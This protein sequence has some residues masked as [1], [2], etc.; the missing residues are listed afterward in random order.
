MTERRRSRVHP[1]HHRPRLEDFSGTA[2]E[3]P[4]YPCADGACHASSTPPQCAALGPHT[5][6]GTIPAMPAHGGISRPRPRRT[7]S[8][9]VFLIVACGAPALLTLP[10]C[11]KALY[12]PNDDRTQYDRYRR[13]RSELAPAYIEDEFGRRTPNL[14]ER[15]GPGR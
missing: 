11:Q 14:R 4:A 5:R 10:G 6:G 8:G 1:D 9:G 15:L 3:K 12:P 7:I 2:S 13:A